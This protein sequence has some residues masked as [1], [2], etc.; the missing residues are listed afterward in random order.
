MTR[1]LSPA[2]LLKWVV[3]LTIDYAVLAAVLYF[4]FG[5]PRSSLFVADRVVAAIVIALIASAAIAWMVRNILSAIRN[6]SRPSS[7][8]RERTTAPLPRGS[9]G[10]D[11][12]TVDSNP[13]T[14]GS[15]SSANAE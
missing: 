12:R 2:H 6:R 15:W 3:V 9:R 4:A 1:A 10:R 8:R 14:A 11:S 5:V 13:H 7:R